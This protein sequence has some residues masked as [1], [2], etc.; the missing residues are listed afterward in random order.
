MPMPDRASEMVFASAVLT[1]TG[2]AIA[3]AAHKD[4]NNNIFFIIFSL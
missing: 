3:L 2:E 1:L 4:N